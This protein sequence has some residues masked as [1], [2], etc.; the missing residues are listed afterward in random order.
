M[1]DVKCARAF[2]VTI[3]LVAVGEGGGRAWQSECTRDL[4]P[5]AAISKPVKG[6]CRAGCWVSG[7]T[8]F[9]WLARVHTPWQR[10]WKACCDIVAVDAKYVI[11]SRE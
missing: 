9:S 5:R 11:R 7:H 3:W 4:L 6:E 8:R 10:R 1:N 2:G